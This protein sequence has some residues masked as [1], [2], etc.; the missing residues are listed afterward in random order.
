MD[1][2]EGGVA[3]ILTSCSQE[4]PRGTAPDEIVDWVI[5]GF[6]SLSTET[7][8]HAKDGSHGRCRDHGE[9]KR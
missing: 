8:G 5:W 2:E 7:C 1:W 4:D 9:S 6:P 3:L